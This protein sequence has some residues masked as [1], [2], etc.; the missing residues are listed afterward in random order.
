MPIPRSAPAPAPA[1]IPAPEKSPRPEAKPTATLTR[2]SGEITAALRKARTELLACGAEHKVSG[3]VTIAVTVSVQGRVVKVEL[4]RGSDEF[5]ACLR[6]A[7]RDVQMSAADG[8]TEF[9]YPLI[10]PEPAP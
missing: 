7:L 5:A 4:T 8:E 9:R 1:H 6:Y 2:T 3:R 10:F